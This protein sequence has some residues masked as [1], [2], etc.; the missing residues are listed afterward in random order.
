M[1]LSLKEVQKVAK[2]A[3]I[4]LADGQAE[5]YQ[6]D[7]NR[8]FEWIDELQEVKTQGVEPL[9]N[10]HDGMC[11]LFDDVVTESNK[12]D[13][14]LANSPIKPIQNFYRVPKVLE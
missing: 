10:V 9:Y 13:K 12:V 8:I 2:L 1:S 4:R 3:R 7:L 11:P 6:Q 5:K 14:V